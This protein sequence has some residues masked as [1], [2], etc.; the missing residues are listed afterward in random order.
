[1]DTIICPKC[2]KTAANEIFGLKDGSAVIVFLCSNCGKEFSICPRC[3]GVVPINHLELEGSP[4][5][6]CPLCKKSLKKIACPKCKQE[7]WDDFKECPHCKIKLN[8]SKCTCCKEKIFKAKKTKSCP[9][10]ETFFS[11]RCPECFE[12][13]TSKNF[14]ERGNGQCPACG[15]KFGWSKATQV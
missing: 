6:V 14:D 1:M 15:K 2:Q 10:C 9:H 8:E 12:P 5:I 11:E 13:L 4:V 7:I 3:N